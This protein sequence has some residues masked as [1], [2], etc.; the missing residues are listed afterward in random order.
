MPHVNYRPF[1]FI[2]ILGILFHGCIDIGADKQNKEVQI[3]IGD[4]QGHWES[5]AIGIPVNIDCDFKITGTGLPAPTG[6][7]N[8]LQYYYNITD[9]TVDCYVKC[10]VDAN[11]PGATDNPVYV[12]QLDNERIISVEDGHKVKTNIFENIST[13]DVAIDDSTES[14]IV[15][16]RQQNRDGYSH[17]AF[18]LNAVTAT[19]WS[20]TINEAI[21]LGDP[22]YEEAYNAVF[23]NF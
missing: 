19:E 15:L 18:T 11:L 3:N 22:D 5:R 7:R 16:V 9:N 23:N 8:D 13:Y 1:T 14:S 4:L 20:E 10:I 17:I 2:L 6:L 21:S 12:L